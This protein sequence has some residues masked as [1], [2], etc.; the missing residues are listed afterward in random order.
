[1]GGQVL[2]A[3]LPARGRVKLSCARGEVHEVHAIAFVFA[4][5]SGQ[6]LGALLPACGRVELLHLE[7]TAFGV[8]LVH[9]G[10][11]EMALVLLHSF[12]QA[13]RAL[14][15]V[16]AHHVVLGAGEGNIRGGEFHL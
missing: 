1:M 16:H 11:V 8:A 15:V 7:E 4:H 10:N 9:A 12:V 2:G 13:G 3:C 6:V 5:V 14:V